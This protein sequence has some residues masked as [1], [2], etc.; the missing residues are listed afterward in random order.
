MTEAPDNTAGEQ[1]PLGEKS[2]QHSQDLTSKKDNDFVNVSKKY[3][4]C[5]L[6]NNVVCSNDGKTFGKETA[7]N[8][9]I[10]LYV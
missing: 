4:F 3:Y 1:L 10:A 8:M 6:L 7:K 2:N 5:F 9:I